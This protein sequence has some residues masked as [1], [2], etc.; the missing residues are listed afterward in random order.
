MAVSNTLGEK[1]PMF[2]MGNSAS[3][4]F[5]KDICNLT[6]RYRSQKKAW[7]DGTLFVE[8]LHQLNH[9]FQMQGRKIVMI[10]D[11][12]SAHPE[13]SELKGINLQFTSHQIPL[14]I[15]CRWIRG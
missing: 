5:F 1:V 12:C 2:M 15:G 9:K 10:A 3:S 13:V 8:W 6:C 11:N 14:P 4:R 7:I